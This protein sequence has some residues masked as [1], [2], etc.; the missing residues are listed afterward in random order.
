MERAPE[1][2]PF[3]LFFLRAVQKHHALPNTSA[4]GARRHAVVSLSQHRLSQ[5]LCPRLSCTV[6]HSALFAAWPSVCCLK[7][8]SRDRENSRGQGAGA[9]YEMVA[10]TKRRTF[11][12]LHRRRSYRRLRDLA[13]LDHAGNSKTFCTPS[14]PIVPSSGASSVRTRRAV[15]WRHAPPMWRRARATSVP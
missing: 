7:E 10:R 9:P 2:R 15:G 11:A 12:D 3:F 1:G 8:E 14:L 6:P 4:A 5:S 13:A